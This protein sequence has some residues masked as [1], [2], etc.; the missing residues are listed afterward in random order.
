MASVDSLSWLAQFPDLEQ[1]EDSAKAI[2]AKS[3]RLVEAPV[4]FIGYIEGDA[5]NA[6]V[7]RLS[8]QSRV[9]K[10]SSSGREIFVI[11]RGCWR[12]LCD[13][14]NLFTWQ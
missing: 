5:C 9:Y 11:S 3:A 13:Y 7:M 14:Y 1:L 2:L 10:M 8:G 12:N 6:Y 4:G